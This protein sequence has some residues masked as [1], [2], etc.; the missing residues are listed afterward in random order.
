MPDRSHIR[1]HIGNTM[2]DLAG[3]IAIAS[4]LGCLNE[5]WAGLDSKTAFAVFMNAFGGKRFRLDIG[6]YVPENMRHAELANSVKRSRRPA[7][8]GRKRR[9]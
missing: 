4:R 8:R 6:C 7:A 5:I 9:S 2:H 3:C 1:F